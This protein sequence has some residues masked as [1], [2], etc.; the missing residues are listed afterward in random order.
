MN[1]LTITPRELDKVLLFMARIPYWTRKRII[2]AIIC[3][4]LHV[5]VV[6][7]VWVADQHTPRVFN[8][9]QCAQHTSP[10]GVTI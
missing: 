8:I 7:N 10:R 9:Q 3:T 2:L 1:D 6:V 5:A 4:A